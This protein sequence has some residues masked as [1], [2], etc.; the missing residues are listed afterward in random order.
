[1]KD[2]YFIYFVYEYQGDS[3]AGIPQ[4]RDCEIISAT[5][6][7]VKKGMISRDMFNHMHQLALKAVEFNA[8]VEVSPLD[9]TILTWNIVRNG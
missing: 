3:D 4:Y 2:K 5:K 7:D 9:I 8:N 1:M 6:K